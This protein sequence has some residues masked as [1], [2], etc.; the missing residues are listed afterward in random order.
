MIPSEI[1]IFYLEERKAV[2]MDFVTA[3]DLRIDDKGDDYTIYMDSD[4]NE[5]IRKLKCQLP[6]EVDRSLVSLSRDMT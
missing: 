6:W 4:K 5:G 3:K 1:E 2:V